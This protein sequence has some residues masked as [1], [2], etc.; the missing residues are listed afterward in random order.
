MPTTQQFNGA[1]GTGTPRTRLE[2]ALIEPA[3]G[4]HQGLLTGRTRRIIA[5]AGAAALLV[6]GASGCEQ[7]STSSP[8][9]KS[10]VAPKAP[11]APAELAQAWKT[12]PAD[13]DSLR[14]KLM[15]T[16][17]TNT[18]Y[19]IGRGTGVEILDPATGKKLGTV[20]PP[21]PD[22]HPCGMTEGLTASGL[23]AV[24]WVKGDPLH[25]EASCDR[26]SL[27]DTRNGSK[28]TWTKQINGVPLKGK[29]LTDDTTRLAFLAGEILAV[30]TPNTVVGLRTDGAEAW[31]WRNAGVPAEQYVLNWDMSAHHDRIMVMI[32]MEGGSELWRYWVATLDATGR[33]VSA[34]PV[35]MP[36]PSRG[37]VDLVGA[38]PMAAIVR[39]GSSDKTTKP[40]LVTF[41]RDGSV[42]RRIPLASSAG[43]IQ[44]RETSRLSRLRRFDIAFNGSTA[45]LL[46][47][48]PYSATAPTQVVA[49]D[50]ETG[51]TRWTRPVDTGT[52][53]RFLGADSHAAYVLGGKGSRDM[54][55]YAY[56]ADDGDRT[57]ISTVKAPDAA[58]SMS[59]LVIDY[60]AGNLALVEPGRGLTFGALVFRSP[61]A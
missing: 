30:M 32:G 57:Q 26:I 15:A 42:A 35:P 11:F 25:H 36:V 33:E 55:V 45:Y 54:P 3:A 17:R 46:A 5:A 41:A 38:G 1:E 27:V 44:L 40:E 8:A 37:H 14:T 20:T 21:E 13:G 7:D 31:T 61:G 56:A 2:A 28:I 23:G 34:E 49:L 19:Y 53:P 52:T 60:S 48:D 43:D 47:G 9:G 4:A 12:P 24:A 59:G 16:W 18:A 29:P 22:M 58:M 6:T 39:P 51:T 50:L 10:S